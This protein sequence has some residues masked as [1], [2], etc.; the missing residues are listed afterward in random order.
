VEAPRA[1][2]DRRRGA[3]DM[4]ARKRWTTVPSFMSG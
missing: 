4:K 1:G 3:R 2:D